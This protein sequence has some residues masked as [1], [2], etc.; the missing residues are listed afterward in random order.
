V[1]PAAVAAGEQQK[2]EGTTAAAYAAAALTNT[3][4]QPRQLTGWPWGLPCLPLAPAV[5]S[6]QCVDQP[7]AVQPSQL[8]LSPP[9]AFQAGSGD[10]LGEGTTTAA[11]A[12]AA[13]AAAVSW[14][15]PSTLT[16]HTSGQGH[17]VAAAWRLTVPEV[18]LRQLQQ[19]R[20]LRYPSYSR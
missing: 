8:C 17:Q 10:A 12:A 2:P 4:Q 14:Q 15:L 5:Q 1:A 18:Q 6:T 13:A 9:A 3:W 11:A 20:L 19:A 7:H 16:A